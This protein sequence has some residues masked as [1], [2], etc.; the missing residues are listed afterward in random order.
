VGAA[1]IWT[2]RADTPPEAWLSLMPEKP[3]ELVI[4][5]RVPYGDGG[6]AGVEF[7]A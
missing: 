7:R 2:D 3:H 4:L 1:L 6:E 5:I